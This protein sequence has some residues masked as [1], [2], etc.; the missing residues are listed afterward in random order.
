MPLQTLTGF[1][2]YSLFKTPNSTHSVCVVLIVVVLV[3]IV[4]VLFPC[5]VV[6]VEQNLLTSVA[7]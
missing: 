3:A 2:K 1:L 7:D 6:I 4:E 5:V